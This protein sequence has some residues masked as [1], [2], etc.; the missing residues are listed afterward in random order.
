MLSF[1][2]HHS[3]AIHQADVPTA[4]LNASVDKEIYMRQP[5]GFIL[6]P[7]GEG[8]LV[9]RLKRAIYGLKQAGRR[10]WSLFHTFIV[11]M[12]FTQSGTDMCQYYLECCE[13]RTFLAIYVDDILIVSTSERI[14]LNTL[15]LLQERFNI[16]VLG[17]TTWILSLHI[18]H[19]ALG[20]TL[21]QSSYIC[22]ILT[23]YGMESCNPA[24]TVS[25]PL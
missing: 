20:I 19:E 9:C 4:Y 25:A 3:L 2:A 1:A 7:Q 8:E 10:W 11:D 22:D 15:D 24:Y 21:D 13:H 14:H 23:R 12:G 17:P 18:T 16:K 5:T 6:R